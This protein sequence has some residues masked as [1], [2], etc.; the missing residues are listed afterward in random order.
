MMKTIKEA[1]RMSPSEPVITIKYS[2]NNFPMKES[3]QIPEGITLFVPVATLNMNPKV[4]FYLIF[5]SYFEF[6]N[7][8]ILAN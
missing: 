7:I 3:L 2:K 6:K 4:S 1:E 5:T 8:L